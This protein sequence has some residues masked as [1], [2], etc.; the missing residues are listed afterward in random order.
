MTDDDY[1]VIKA[2]SKSNMED[3]F[4]NGTI[5]CKTAN[6]FQFVEDNNLRGD[7]M[8][9]WRTFTVPKE[10]NHFLKIWIDKTKDPIAVFHPVELTWKPP[11]IFTNIFCLTTVAGKE[12]Q[13]GGLIHSDRRLRDFGS[14]YVSFH[15]SQAFYERVAAAIARSGYEF[16]FKKV[17]Y[18]P[19]G[20]LKYNITGFEKTDNYSWQKEARFFIYTPVDEI[21]KFNIGSVADIGALHEFPE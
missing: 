4:H 9:G 18:F 11:D 13:P 21:L 20:K 8:E 2:G 1:I 10:E 17:Q 7:D 19:K 3:L 12:I 14:H 16:K 5:Y 15:D 6:Y